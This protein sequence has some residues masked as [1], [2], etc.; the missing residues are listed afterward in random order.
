MTTPEVGSISQASHRFFGRGRPV[1]LPNRP[2]VRRF[3]PLQ[4]SEGLDSGF[5]EYARRFRLQQAASIVSAT[6]ARACR[7][8]RTHLPPIY[9]CPTRACILAMRR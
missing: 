4:A 3:G 9:T 6:F 2:L 7:I 8:V 1:L 5:L